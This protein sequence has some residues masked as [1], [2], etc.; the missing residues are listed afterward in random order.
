MAP[1]K[2]LIAAE[3]QY[4]LVDDWYQEQV[5]A[6][7]KDRFHTPHTWRMSSPLYME[8][9]AAM[10]ERKQEEILVQDSIDEYEWYESMREGEDRV[11]PTYRTKAQEF[12]DRNIQQY[13]LKQ[14][15]PTNASYYN[16]D[17]TLKNLNANKLEKN[18]NVLAGLQNQILIDQRAS[19]SHEPPPPETPELELTTA[20]PDPKKIPK[21]GEKEW[22][23]QG[24]FANSNGKVTMPERQSYVQNPVDSL[25]DGREAKILQ[26]VVE[27]GYSGAWRYGETHSKDVLAYKVQEYSEKNSNVIVLK[28]EID[29]TSVQEDVPTP[30]E[31]PPQVTEKIELPPET[32]KKIEEDEIRREELGETDS[33]ATDQIRMFDDGSFDDYKRWTPAQW[34][35]SLRN[36]NQKEVNKTILSQTYRRTEWEDAC[37]EIIYEYV[38]RRGLVALDPQPDPESDRFKNA[39]LPTTQILAEEHAIASTRVYDNFIS[40]EPTMTVHERDNH[41]TQAVDTLTEQ[42]TMGAETTLAAKKEQKAAREPKI[43]Q[44][45]KEKFA[46]HKDNAQTVLRPEHVSM[47]VGHHSTMLPHLSKSQAL[48]DVAF[49]KEFHVA[50]E[51]QVTKFWDET[52]YTY[53]KPSFEM[54]FRPYFH[55]EELQ[56]LWDTLPLWDESFKNEL[57]RP[58][59]LSDKEAV[60]KVKERLLQD[61]NF[62]PRS[63]LTPKPQPARRQP[64]PE[65]E[66]R[67]M[68][69]DCWPG[70]SQPVGAENRFQA[71]QSAKAKPKYKRRRMESR[72]RD[73]G[74]D[75]N[76]SS[77]RFWDYIELTSKVGSLPAWNC[78]RF[79]WVSQAASE[80][81]RH[82]KEIRNS[83][84]WIERENF[85]A[86]MYDRLEKRWKR[87]DNRK[88][89]PDT[90]EDKGKTY[91]LWENGLNLI[92]F[93]VY[94]CEKRRWQILIEDSEICD[95]AGQ[96]QK[97][98]THIRAVQGHSGPNVYIEDRY[99]V[100]STDTRFIY[101]V[102]KRKNLA[103]IMENGLVPENHMV[104]GGRQDI[105]FSAESQET[106]IERQQQH[107]HNN[108]HKDAGR[109]W[110][111][112]GY[113]YRPH[114][115]HKDDELM[116]VKVHLPVAMHTYKAQFAQTSTCAI[117]SSVAI[118]TQAIIDARL[119]EGARQIIWR[120]PRFNQATAGTTSL[121]STIHD[122]HCSPN[123]T[124]ETIA[125]HRVDH[126][127]YGSIEPSKAKEPDL[128]DPPRS[129]DID[130][131]EEARKQNAYAA[132]AKANIERTNI[133]ITQNLTVHSEDERRYYEDCLTGQEQ[134]TE[135][136]AQ[137]AQAQLETIPDENKELIAL[138][139]TA[140][141][142]KIIPWQDIDQEIKDSNFQ[143][144]DIIWAYNAQ[145]LA[146][147]W[148][149][150][151]LKTWCEKLNKG[152][153]S[154]AQQPLVFKI[155]K[156]HGW[157]VGGFWSMTRPNRPALQKDLLKLYD[158]MVIHE[159]THHKTDAWTAAFEEL[160]AEARDH[161]YRIT[162]TVF[163]ATAQNKRPRPVTEEAQFRYA[164]EKDAT[165]HWR[166]M[167]CGKYNP[168]ELRSCHDCGL[169][170][171]DTMDHM[172]HLQADKSHQLLAGEI[173][174][175]YI[176]KCYQILSGKVDVR[177]RETLI[178]CKDARRTTRFDEWLNQP[179][180]EIGITRENMHEQARIYEELR[181]PFRGPNANCRPD[182]ERRT[183]GGTKHDGKPPWSQLQKWAFANSF[184]SSRRVLSLASSATSRRRRLFSCIASWMA[185][186]CIGWLPG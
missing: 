97:T 92:P 94:G 35:D 134:Q 70:R 116:E 24:M 33:T 160:P 185:S 6:I 53:T 123:V 64:E 175:D 84:G 183:K 10:P 69:K 129:A 28:G 4:P 176:A 167:V 47:K 128:T 81:A 32:I 98:W 13:S 59:H 115:D 112:Q 103:S 78:K 166:C 40:A 100:K 68:A 61:R 21:R 171:P 46:G 182:Q 42:L 12:E 95:E 152:L 122:Q 72:D 82:W 102:T 56:K 34:K 37:D 140:V 41:I 145:E 151:E 105:Y 165:T 79:N 7:H 127:F 2:K 104:Y 80:P 87:R 67:T 174:N 172:L 66:G 135:T 161:Y 170:F 142:A 110:V 50:A 18:Y 180:N 15:W 77:T 101:H 17:A 108:N 173:C 60:A 73:R 148:L 164:I 58:D 163:S 54:Q 155:L 186:T 51:Y 1:Y 52:G 63:R 99:P 178:L 143:P 55:P 62:N 90:I 113:Y 75:E 38:P 111:P 107:M 154:T 124:T 168:N 137:A 91:N 25:P 19:S 3:V 169:I 130:A 86:L 48:R 27:E 120:N 118:G 71:K 8:Q 22:I 149:N 44:A 162:G 144:K 36:H 20:A 96:P 184:C 106:I 126:E 45:M 89:H 156:H 133:L 150:S 132:F 57:L 117:L 83:E 49:P 76:L 39:I 5:P 26:T 141:T 9:F 181:K 146:G 119:M 158:K 114:K 11:H 23:N 16:A 31:L 30:V 74:I 159:N 14:L 131:E 177:A 29:P 147:T 43:P 65:R 85:L 138:A 88:P 179:V 109:V 139:A 153:A 93:L 157:K 136:A 125:Q 121:S